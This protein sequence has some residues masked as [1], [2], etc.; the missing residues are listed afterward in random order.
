MESKK[1][2]GKKSSEVDFAAM[3]IE[4][5][6][7]MASP[8]IAALRAKK[9]VMSKEERNRRRREYDQRRRATTVAVALRAPD[10]ESA[11]AIREMAARLKSVA[12]ANNW[13]I[14][15]VVESA[16]KRMPVGRRKAAPKPKA[17]AKKS[18][19]RKKSAA[20][21]GAKPIASPAAAS[22]G[23]AASAT[24]LASQDIAAPGNRSNSGSE[25]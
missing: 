19:P 7:Q 2:S 1:P 11:A 13:S 15:E 8:M 4:E 12:Q 14:A 3:S 16:L 6:E 18:A 25:Q 17:A 23:E 9:E 10:K 22:S 24:P 20:K 21:I 5:L